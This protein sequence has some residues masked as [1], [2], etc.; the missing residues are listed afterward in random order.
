MSRMGSPRNAFESPL[1][2]LRGLINPNDHGLY[3]VVGNVWEWCADWFSAVHDDVRSDP[4]GPDA[5]TARVIRGGSYLC[6]C[7]Y[8]NRYRAAERSANMP[9]ST[10][11]N[12]GFRCAAKG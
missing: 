11:G 12:T 4:Q 6:H 10:S 3:N 1:P 8:C 5:G 9:D 2:V 7:P